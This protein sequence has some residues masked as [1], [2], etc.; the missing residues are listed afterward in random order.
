MAVEQSWR[1]NIEN[2][3]SSWFPLCFRRCN[4]HIGSDLQGA[5]ISQELWKS[6]IVSVKKADISSLFQT[7]VKTTYKIVRY[8]TE[9]VVSR[10]QSF[11][12]LFFLS[13]VS[14]TLIS[15]VTLK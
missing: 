13:Q 6:N 15:E 10:T 8:E 1:L 12:L 7:S 3:A 2:Y 4:T 11:F 5:V 14:L 9:L